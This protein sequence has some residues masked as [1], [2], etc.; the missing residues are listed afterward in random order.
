MFYKLYDPPPYLR[1]YVLYAWVLEHIGNSNILQKFRIIPDGIPAIIY[2]DSYN[3]FSNSCGD[4]SPQLYIY[5]PYTKFS[6]EWV[7]GDFRTIGIYLKPYA[8]K[9][10]F[11]RDASDFLNQNINLSDVVHHT[12]LEHLAQAQDVNLKINILFKFIADQIT[13]NANPNNHKINAIIN[14]LATGN[15]LPQVCRETNISERT[16]ERLMNQ[17]VGISPKRFTRIIRL[18]SFLDG[19]RNGVHDN[20]TDLA[21]IND[22]FDQ[23]HSI[24]EFKEFTGITPR[25]FFVNT[26]ELLKNFP[27]FKK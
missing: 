20:F 27:S 24:R 1:E 13:L 22:Y 9:S 19:F 8:L 3:Y 18:Q 6:D 23:S 7:I 4:H 10:I 12:L 14:L 2:Q 16:L 25:E 5:G 11:N 15:S 26:K 17:H 21:Y